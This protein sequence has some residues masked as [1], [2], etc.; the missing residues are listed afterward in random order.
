MPLAFIKNSRLPSFIVG[1]LIVPPV[2]HVMRFVKDQTFLVNLHS[3]ELKPGPLGR[4]VAFL[5]RA[6]AFL[7]RLYQRE[8]DAYASRKYSRYIRHHYGRDGRGYF[9]Y[10]G[11]GDAEKAALFGKPG[12]R[13]NGFIERYSDLLGY[14][15]GDTFF[16]AGCGRGQN[17]KVLME[18]FPRSP[19]HGIDF[20]AEAVSVINLAVGSEPVS[21]VQGDLTDAA[22]FVAFGDGAFD[23]VVMSHVL[24]IIIGDGTQ[25]TKDTR[26]AILRE[27]ARL[28]RKTVLVID[29]PAI[30][31][32]VEGFEIEQKDRGYFAE[33]VLKYFPPDQGTTCVLQS[34]DSIAVLF[35][36]A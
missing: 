4:A 20:S 18:R 32:Q 17:I 3:A 1:R 22:T 33:S 9:S 26:A 10:A 19:I 8:F 35:R 2:F 31:S 15:D 13:I 36:K 24:S 16:D 25:E 28:A 34:A 29:S 30:V 11:L 27:L 7:G 14:A 23:H 12:G 21:A 5:A 6:A